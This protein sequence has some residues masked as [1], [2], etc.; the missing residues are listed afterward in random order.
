MSIRSLSQHQAFQSE[1][2]S[3][4]A[5]QIDDR[6][7]ERSPAAIAVRDR[8]EQR[9]AGPAGAESPT[10]HECEVFGVSPRLSVMSTTIRDFEHA[11]HWGGWTVSQSITDASRHWR[12]L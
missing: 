6:R 8:V 3:F 10:K 11:L 2:E 7:V 5:A 12:R 4:W 9:E 1:S